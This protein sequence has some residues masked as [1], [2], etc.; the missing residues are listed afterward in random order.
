MMQKVS[1]RRLFVFGL[2]LSVS[3]ALFGWLE[4]VFDYLG[5]APVLDSRENLGW[6]AQM[7]EGEL[8]REP[9]YRAILY[10]WILTWLPEKLWILATVGFFSHCANAVFVGLIARSVWHKPEAMYFSGVLYLVYPVAI[11]FSGQL[12]DITTGMTVFLAAVWC[13]MDRLEA[14]RGELETAPFKDLSG[15]LIAGLL[16]GCAVLIRPN[17]LPASLALAA[18]PIIYGYLERSLR[19]MTAWRGFSYCLGCLLPLLGQGV[20]NLQHAGE[21][22][23]LPWQG[24][25][26]LYAANRPGANGKFYMQRVSFE[27][28]PD[29]ENTTRMESEYLYQM[30]TG[31]RPPLNISAM[32]DYWRGQLVASIQQDPVRWLSLMGRKVAYLFNDWEQYNNLSY[33]Y[34]K[35]RLNLLRH[36]PLGWGILLILA[37]AACLFAFKSADRSALMLVLYVILTYAAGLL[38]FFVSAR[39]RLPLVPLLAVISGGCVCSSMTF[40]GQGR[41][42]L[43]PAFVL[44]MVALI[45]YGN[46]FNAKDESTFIQDELLLASSAARLAD[47]AAALTYARAA[48]RKDP[49][50]QTARRIEVTS[51]FNLWLKAH[52]P[53]VRNDLWADLCNSL[54]K[55]WQ[56]DAATKFIEGVYYWRTHESDDA[57]EAWEAAVEKSPESAVF[58]Q[59]AL[60]WVKSAQ[61]GN[62]FEGNDPILESIL[63]RNEQDLSE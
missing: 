28:V 37:A 32:N 33:E 46:W 24:A 51:L 41:R 60:N 58:S 38:L 49:D 27:Q 62:G 43:L 30:E 11:Y 10:P 53:D 20:F 8:P 40:R 17:F 54:P 44:P 26:N 14:S 55:V 25:Y 61:S 57:I 19:V 39:F 52:R 9:L 2:I 42:W 7:I 31:E 12:L 29:G 35:S 47:D 6:M 22:T 56:W 59:R 4:W 45:S 48:L 23:V 15:Y 18:S 16:A 3:Y 1:F 63:H 13:L 34:Q 21:F 36:N 5:Q 50:R